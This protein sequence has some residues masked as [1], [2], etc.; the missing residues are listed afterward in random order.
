M[1]LIAMCC[2]DTEENGRSKYTKATLEMLFDTVDFD[3][4]RL[5]IVDNDSCEET[6]HIISEF[7][8]CT[9]SNVEAIELDENIGTARAINKAWALRKKGEHLIKMDN[10][11]LVNYSGWVDEMEEV[12]ARDPSIGILGLKRKDLLENPW[13]TDHFKSTLRMLPHVNGQPWIIVED[14][15]HV[16]GTC[17][18][19]NHRLIDKIGGLM[20]PGVYGFDDTLAAVRCKLA[21]FKNSFLPHIDIEHIDYKETPYWQEKKDL[22]MRDMPEFNQMK[23]DL[24]SGKLNTF[25]KL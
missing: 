25:V 1:A 12:I 23:A 20:Q 5:I 16:I 18:M 19:Y 21:G 8:T 3:K 15:E 9:N 4:H 2:Y 24:I 14:V 13:R 22:A 6:K 10:D 7:L 17:Q 11:C